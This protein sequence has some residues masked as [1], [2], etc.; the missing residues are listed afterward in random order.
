MQQSLI[1]AAIDLLVERGWAA[2]TAVAVCERA[3]CTRGALIHHYPNLSAL[4][5]H[6]LESL[7]DEFV[8]APRPVPTTMLS[9]VD[10]VWRAASDPR[11]KAVIEAW[12]AAGNDRELARE[13]QPAMMRFAKL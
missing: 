4:L 1:D 8:S 2:S 6:A 13:L 3:G 12:L 10:A 7:Y 5:A 9:A 11:F